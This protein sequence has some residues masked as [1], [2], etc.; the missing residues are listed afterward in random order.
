MAVMVENNYYYNPAAVAGG[1]RAVP[2][3][4]HRPAEADRRFLKTLSMDDDDDEDNMSWRPPPSPFAH[5]TE[6]APQANFNID[7][8]RQNYL[9]SFKFNVQFADDHEQEI[10][11]QITITQRITQRIKRWLSMINNGVKKSETTKTTR[12]LK[13]FGHR[14]Q[15]VHCI[16][17]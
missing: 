4:K 10:I 16:A 15:K 3:G 2:V 12:K 7:V 14:I 9:R 8:G 1:G 6:R 13:S 17:I 5:P 11:S